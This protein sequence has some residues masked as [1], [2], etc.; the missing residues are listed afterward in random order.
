MD[1]IF[2]V[3]DLDENEYIIDV[4]NVT[5]RF[6]KSTENINDLKEYFVKHGL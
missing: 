5:V 2:S 6:N 3:P 1:N 4:N